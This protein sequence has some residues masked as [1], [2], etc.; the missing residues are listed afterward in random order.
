MKMA[1]PIETTPTLF[2]KDALNFIRKMEEAMQ[3]KVSSEEAARLKKN[4]DSVIAN[5]K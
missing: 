3:K 5:S 4:F 2:G 1:R